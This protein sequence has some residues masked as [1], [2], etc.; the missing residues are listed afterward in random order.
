[1]LN[2]L[3]RYI[4]LKNSIFWNCEIN[5]DLE[6]EDSEKIIFAVNY[7]SRNKL[8][9][10]N[11]TIYSTVVQETKADMALIEM[12]EEIFNHHLGKHTGGFREND[13]FTN[14]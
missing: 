10:T 14:R 1:M 5:S 11:D 7:S 3:K 2:E 13:H 8:L 9:A 6:I 4:I 12:A